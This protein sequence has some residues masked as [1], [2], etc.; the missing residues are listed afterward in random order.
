MSNFVIR[1]ATTDDAVIIA[2]VHQIS[3]QLAYRPILSEELLNAQTLAEREKYWKEQTALAS[4]SDAEIYVAEHRAVIDESHSS[5]LVNESHH[6][7]PVN[8]SHHSPPVDEPQASPPVNEPQIVGFIVLLKHTDQNG[9]NS[10]DRVKDNDADGEIDRI[11]VHPDFMG[12]GAGKALM[13]YALERLK[14]LGCKKAFLWVFEA[15]STA[16]EFYQ[17]MGFSTDGDRRQIK[18]YPHDLLYTRTL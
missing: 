14:A 18:P 8:E 13:S 10:G 7:P 2:G 16:R 4:A 3:R 5:L 17:A 1:Q 15:N 12:K 9:L 6:S 11:Y